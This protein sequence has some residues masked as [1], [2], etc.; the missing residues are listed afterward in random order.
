MLQKCASGCRRHIVGAEEKYAII[1]EDE[2]IFAVQV[3]FG[4]ITIVGMASERRLREKILL[5]DIKSL[6]NVLRELFNSE[7]RFIIFVMNSTQV[8]V[9][10]VLLYV[11]ESIF[12]DFL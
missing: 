8:P 10:S 7:S 9:K 2:I 11:Q 6:D 1:L 5:G 12:T 3:F 4:I